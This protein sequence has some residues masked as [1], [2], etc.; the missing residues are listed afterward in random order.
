MGYRLT[1]KNPDTD[2]IIVDNKFFGYVSDEDRRNSRSLRWLIENHKLDDYDPEER[3]E[4]WIWDYGSYHEMFLRHSEFLEF[5]VL[6][7]MDRN[8][9]YFVDCD[10][11]VHDRI[12]Y[13]EV[14]LSLPWVKIGWY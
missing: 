8:D 10:P 14:A 12:E 11:N 5:I 13:Y 2:E 4:S 3:L 1:I 6:Y 7:I 9:F